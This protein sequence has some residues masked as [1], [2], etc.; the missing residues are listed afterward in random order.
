M[1]K[2]KLNK[3]L[4]T[5]PTGNRYT[6]KT[7][8]TIARLIQ[9]GTLSENEVIAQLGCSKSSINRWVADY[10]NGYHDSDSEYSAFAR[11][12]ATVARISY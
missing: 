8:K 7:Q 12:K 10:N 4:G 11:T 5:K 9:S 3:H 1:K 2:L 6:T